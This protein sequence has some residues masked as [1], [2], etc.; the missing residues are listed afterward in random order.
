[1]SAVPD[2]P[3]VVCLRVVDQIGVSMTIASGTEQRWCGQCGLPVL[4]SATGLEFMDKN[5]TGRILCVQCARASQNAAQQW[6]LVPGAADEMRAM[7]LSEQQVR[8]GWQRVRRDPMKPP[9]N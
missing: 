1:M 9:L 8:V 7:G 4:I 6:G 5:P 3:I 2:G